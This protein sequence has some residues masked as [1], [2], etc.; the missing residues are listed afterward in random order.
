MKRSTDSIADRQ[1]DAKNQH[2]VCLDPVI[3]NAARLG[4]RISPASQFMTTP[5]EHPGYWQ[6]QD[7]PGTVAQGVDWLAEVE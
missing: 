4:S 7:H 6:R 5:P 2:A 3:P 1:G